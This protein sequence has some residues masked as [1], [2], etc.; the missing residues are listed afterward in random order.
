MQSRHLIDLSDLSVNEWEDITRL[1]CDIG[2]NIDSYYGAC[3][4]K[5]LATLFYEPSTR[6][7]MSFQT[8]MLRLGGRI[9]GFD[10]P[11]NSSVAKGESLKDTI[12]VVSGYSD[13]IAM[14][15]PAAGSAMAASLYSRVPII[16]AGD[17]GHLHPT[18]TL[19]DLVTLRKEK[20]TFSGLCI[21]LCGDLK[22]GRTVH[23]LIKATAGFPDNR[24]ILIST[25]S[26]GVPLYIKDYLSA[27]GAPWLEVDSLAD[28]MPLL[29]V[30]YMTRIQKERFA[31]ENEYINQR[32]VYILDSYKMSLAK[33]DLIVLHPLPRVDEITVE[34]DDDKRAKYF[35][36]TEY[37]LYARMALIMRMLEGTSKQLPIVPRGTET[38][39]SNP[40]C[41]THRESYVPHTFRKSGDILVCNYCE[42]RTRFD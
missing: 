22:N 19:T 17:G 12:R 11:S 7:Q 34:V 14:R 31:S 39:C 8:A 32:G 15:H 18:Q 5:I 29:D 23:S 28:A 21:G 33:K 36:Q 25:P 27:M 26:L 20:G 1:A 2:A 6:T 41:I 38:E 10:N 3:R 16:N 37:G 4:G 9:I 13:I 42:E 24:F 35:E 40:E 30:L